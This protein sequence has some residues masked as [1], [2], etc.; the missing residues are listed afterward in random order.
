MLQILDKETDNC[1]YCGLTECRYQ[2]SSIEIY[3]LTKVPSIFN[4]K[5]VGWN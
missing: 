5:S 2:K 4:E 1:P 3:K